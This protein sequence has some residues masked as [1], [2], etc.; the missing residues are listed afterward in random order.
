[1]FLSEGADE[2]ESNKLINDIIIKTEKII[3]KNK[4]KIKLKYPKIK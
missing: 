2:E 1:M 4:A 3:N